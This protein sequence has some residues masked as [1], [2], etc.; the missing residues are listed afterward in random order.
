ID[1]VGISSQMVTAQIFKNWNLE[2]EIAEVIKYSL[3]PIDAPENLKKHCYILS[4]I[5]NSINVFG[6]LLPDQI[7][8]TTELLKLYNLDAQLF[9]SAIE[10][11]QH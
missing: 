3:N 8:S 7:N 6:T 1:M 4:V 2:P 10:K 9:F 5:S 11:V